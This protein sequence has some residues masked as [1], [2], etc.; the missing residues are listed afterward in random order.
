[1]KVTLTSG[2]QFHYNDR[3]CEVISWNSRIVLTLD[4]LSKT[5]IR[6]PEIELLEGIENGS[7]KLINEETVGNER[8]Q[9]KSKDLNS[10]NKSEKE[11]AEYRH[12]FIKGLEEEG[13]FSIS[14]KTQVIIDSI[15]ENNNLKPPSWRSVSRWRKEYIKN[16]RSIRGLIDHLDN[17][18]SYERKRGKLQELIDE[19]IK[20]V[21]LTKERISL[22][23][24]HRQ[25]ET[26]IKEY[27]K[28][29]DDDI[30][31][32]SY[33]TMQREIKKIPPY[34]IKEKR[35]G[36]RQA[37]EE[38]RVTKFHAPP[39]RVLQRAEAD[40]TTLDYFLL[41][42]ET[43]L[44]L[45]RPYITVIIDKYSRVPLGV[46]ISFYEGSYLTV[47]K[48][49]KSALLPK[50]YLKSQF[51]NIKNSFP[52]F[53]KMDE[54]TVDNAREFWSEDL[55][56]ACLDLDIN[57]HYARVKKGWE[58]GSIE[59]FFRRQNARL[60]ENIKGK[61]F[62]SIFKK[63]E[64]DPEKEAIMTFNEFLSVFYK[65]LV[66]IYPYEEIRISNGRVLV[67]H[68]AWVSS[69]NEVPREI[70]SKDSL[71]IILGKTEKRMLKV[72]GVQIDYLKYDSR[73]LSEYRAR[74][75]NNEN[76]L[77]KY[78]PEDMGCIYV[79]NKFS[80]EYFS[81][82]AIDIEYAGGLTYWQHKVIRRYANDFMKLSNKEGENL[83]AA[84]VELNKL[85]KTLVDGKSKKAASKAIAKY[86]G[87]STKEGASVNESSRRKDHQDLESLSTQTMGKRKL[88]NF[89]DE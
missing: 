41:D 12:K 63:Q 29:N 60:I 20:E 87:I 2:M 30:P 56:F 59:N 66:D 67:P 78:N 85:V 5:E 1:M 55:K 51:Q 4:V 33:S 11:R 22:S 19:V 40:H 62:S 7:I 58:K 14:P 43:L 88:R 18:G 13:V 6:I 21:Y 24:T 17:C 74:Y 27:N 38:F 49:L 26:A 10:Y 46:C 47:A 64:Y 76:V 61:T 69:I 45:G 34:E 15:A 52:Y 75:Q 44:P 48:A 68:K 82:P 84:K 8:L 53:G 77:I 16:G 54:L 72:G 57:L 35:E 79:L 42:D 23:E 32:P 73:E 31:V 81:V 71:D 80:G 25:L 39:K 37:K 70:F 28:Q 89:D 9:S 86:R 65:W 83:H 3:L 50:T 36:V